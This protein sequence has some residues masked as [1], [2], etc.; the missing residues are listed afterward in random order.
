[1]AAAHPPPATERWAW[2]CEPDVPMELVLATGTVTGYKGVIK[3]TDQ[4]FAARR[5]VNGKLQHL[6]SSDDPRECA[7]VLARLELEPLSEEAIRS[8]RK[9]LAK[10]RAEARRRERNRRK[11]DARL[12]SRSD[13]LHKSYFGGAGARV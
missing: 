10:V 13:R 8:A 1:M 11:R 7:Y 6:W 9:E 2:C 4:T 12:S 5:K 3:V